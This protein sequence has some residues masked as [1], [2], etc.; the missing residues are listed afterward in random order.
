MSVLLASIITL[1]STQWAPI[2]VDA[3]QDSY[4]LTAMTETNVRCL[5]PSAIMEIVSTHPDHFIVYVTMVS[6]V[7]IVQ[8]MSTNAQIARAYTGH[9]SILKDHLNV[10][11]ITVT[12]ATCVWMMSMNAMPI[13]V[14][15]IRVA[16]TLLDLIN[17]L[18]TPDL[19]R[20]IAMIGMNV[21]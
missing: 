21:L 4:P 2:H 15:Q 8:T 6:P 1:V 5:L 16:L 10:F 14:P 12:K 13:H 9:V 19:S 20:L 17:V 11:A 3:T 18:V 7:H